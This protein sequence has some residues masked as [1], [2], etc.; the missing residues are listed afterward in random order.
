MANNFLSFH[1]VKIAQDCLQQYIK[2]RESVV[3]CVTRAISDVEVLDVKEVPTLTGAQPV[4]VVTRRARSHWELGHQ[5]TRGSVLGCGVHSVAVRAPVG[6][7]RGV[8]V[9]AERVLPRGQEVGILVLQ[10]FNP[11]LALFLG[12]CHQQEVAAQGGIERRPLPLIM[13]DTQ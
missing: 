11:Q 12:L 1:H 6:S 3:L 2:M 10:S 9:D 13:Q 5:W 4:Y 7:L 8:G